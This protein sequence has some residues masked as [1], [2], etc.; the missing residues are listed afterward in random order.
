MVR[1]GTEILLKSLAIPEMCSYLAFY[2]KMGLQGAKKLMKAYKSL[3]R[4][5]DSSKAECL[6]GTAVRAEEHGWEPL[7]T[8]AERRHLN[9]LSYTVYRLCYDL[10]CG[11]HSD[12]KE[13]RA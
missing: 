13:A 3:S 1:G 9:R 12:A 10:E 5:P 2:E 11:I 7:L 6:I 4:K 8:D